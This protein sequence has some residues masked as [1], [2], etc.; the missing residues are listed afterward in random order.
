MIRPPVKGEVIREAL[1]RVKAGDRA[2]TPIDAILKS[3]K[4][5]NLLVLGPTAMVALYILRHLGTLGV[6]TSAESI[7]AVGG[8][9]YGLVRV[10][11]WWRDVKPPEPKARRP[12]SDGQVSGER[13]DDLSDSGHPVRADHLR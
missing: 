9:L 3:R 13:S 5:S 7:S 8:G 6:L 10:G 2:W 12:K 1:S 4:L 11:R